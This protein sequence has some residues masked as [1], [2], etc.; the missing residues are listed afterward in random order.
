MQNPSLRDSP[1]FICGHPKSGTSLLRALFD[2]HPQVVAYP[3]ETVFFRRYLPQAHGKSLED[4]LSLADKTLTHI[5]EW[6]QTNPPAHQ[7][8]HPDRDYSQVPADE[9]RAAMRRFVSGQYRHEGDMLSAAILAYGEATGRL[10][11]D[12][13]YWV[14]KT[15]LNELFA[16]QIFAWWPEARCIHV[17]RDPR[18]NFVSYRRKHPDWTAEFFARNWRRST[19]AGF[20]NRKRLGDGRY[21]LIRYEDFVRDPEAA[22][23]E[24][25]A[26]LGIAD[27]PS[28]R[29]PTRG[30]KIWQGNS[31]FDE[32][33]EGIN[34]SSVGRWR[35]SLG[36]EELYWLESLTGSALR[37]MGY[38]SYSQVAQ[39][40]STV[41]AKVFIAQI[42]LRLREGLRG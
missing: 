7:S 39:G 38:E 41:R 8:G 32:K 4:K 37:R 17:V 3:E 16:A 42:V 29:R 9:V 13:K 35:K 5:F 11:K 31:M 1:V 10:I 14:E 28:M 20:A 12:T 21:K 25:C 19:R 27:D 26:F 22:L 2:T 33:F 36:G 24:L 23:R 15:P 40:P 18:D 30:G 34:D 6:N